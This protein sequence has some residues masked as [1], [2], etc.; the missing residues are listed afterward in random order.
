MQI[1]KVW[2]VC[3]VF[4]AV[5]R[6]TGF[7]STRPGGSTGPGTIKPG[8]GT[9]SKPSWQGK[10]GDGLHESGRGEAGSE[11]HPPR[12]PEATT[13]PGT[14]ETPRIVVS[15]SP[16]GTSDVH[17]R[18]QALGGRRGKQ[19]SLILL[20]LDSGYTALKILR[21]WLPLGRSLVSFFISSN[22]AISSHRFCT[23]FHWCD[24][25][26]IVLDRKPI[27]LWPWFYRL[28]FCSWVLQ[29]LHWLSPVWLDCYC[30]ESCTYWLFTSGLCCVL[31]RPAVLVL[32]PQWPPSWR[33][34][35]LR[36]VRTS[37]LWVRRCPRGRSGSSLR[38]RIRRQPSLR[39][40]APPTGC[41]NWGCTAGHSAA[42]ASVCRRE[43]WG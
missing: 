38:G 36:D 13:E 9:T 26:V 2:I 8:S 31:F 43:R 1:G 14:S 6:H 5:G 27:D 3:F 11:S 12:D 4:I 23:D 25:F 30:F 16:R 34:R 35:R 20:F 21:T 10:E 18:E 41:I 42:P 28:K 32:R 40:R 22:S 17:G 15:T 19:L 29:I 33:L 24:W 39:R 7:G 37:S